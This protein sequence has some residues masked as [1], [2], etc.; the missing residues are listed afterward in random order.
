MSTAKI[1]SFCVQG[2]FVAHWAKDIGRWLTNRCRTGW[3]DFART[4]DSPPRWKARVV[5]VGDGCRGE[6]GLL[7]D[8]WVDT[9]CGEGRVAA[10]GAFERLVVA[11]RCGGDGWCGSISAACCA[12]V[13]VHSAAFGFDARPGTACVAVC[14]LGASGVIDN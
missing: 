11:T 2:W 7:R 8:P 4:A 6:G 14:V 12:C 1:V 13:G 5:G 10:V 3:N 9:G